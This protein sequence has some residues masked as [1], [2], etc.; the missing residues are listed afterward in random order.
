MNSSKLGPFRPIFKTWTVKFDF[1]N[2]EDWF[3]MKFIIINTFS[4]TK[5]LLQ[6]KHNYSQ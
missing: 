4:K 1:I 6:K 2:L 3:F 5:P